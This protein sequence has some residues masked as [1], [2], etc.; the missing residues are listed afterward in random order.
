[1]RTLST[2]G[3]TS[4]NAVISAQDNPVQAFPEPAG[5]NAKELEILTSRRKEPEV[6]CFPRAI[7]KP[8]RRHLAVQAQSEIGAYLAV[9]RRYD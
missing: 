5:V 1:M 6:V 4:A 8:F 2:N 7:L 9:D 3:N